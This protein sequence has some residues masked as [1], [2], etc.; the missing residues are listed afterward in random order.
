[1]NNFP[2]SVPIK[3]DIGKFGLMWPRGLEATSHP[4]SKMLT[5]YSVKG[6]PVEMNKNCSLGHIMTALKRGPHVSAKQPDANRYLLQ[7]TQ[8]KIQQGF[9]SKV[10]WG[11]IKHNHP[12]NLK[13]SPL[14]MI[15]HKSRSYRCILDLSFQLKVKKTL[16]TSVNKDTNVKAPQ[17]SMAQLGTVI[18]RIVYAMADNHNT[19]FPF[20][21]S[22]CDIKDGFWRMVVSLMDAWNFAYTLPSTTTLKNL[23]DIEIIVPHALQMGW[24][25]SPPYFCAATETGRDVI[26]SYYTKND[27]IPKHPLERYLITK[28]K[29][30]QPRNNPANPH[31]SFE[32]Y[33]DD[34]ITLTND[35]S[36]E[37]ITKMARAML[38]GIH[39]IFPPPSITHHQGED[40]I[41][42]K[43]LLQL[44]GMFDY[45]KEILGWN[46]NGKN[47]TIELPVEK[48]HKILEILNKT[49]KLKVIPHKTLEKIQGKLVHIST[50]LPNSRGLLSPLYKAVAQQ[51]HPT[52]LNKNLKQCLTD[53]KTLVTN[54]GSRP[55]SILELVPRDPNYIGFVDASGTGVGGVWTP[56]TSKIQPTVWRV[57]W[58]AEIQANLVSKTNPQGTISINDMETAGILLAWLVLEKI[59]PTV[60]QHKHIGIHCDNDAAV[61]WTQKKSTATST[62][63]GHLLRALALR[64][65]THQAAPLQVI[66]IKGKDNTMADVASRSFHDANLT[67][68]TKFLQSFSQKFPLQQTSWKEYHMPKKIYSKVTS[69]LLGQPS[70]M[71][72]WTKII[73]QERSTGI[74]GQNT[75]THSTSA[76]T[77]QHVPTQ[78]KSYL[79]QDLLQG[80][81]QVT[82]AKEGLSGFR[83]LQKRWQP[84]Q[85]PSN[86]LANLRQST[87]QKKL[88]NCQWHGS[89]KDTGDKILLQHHNLHSQSVCQNNASK[90]ENN[91]TT[92]T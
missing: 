70:T 79:S 20:V 27:A 74:T 81:G 85:R 37:N 63:A 62:I 64:L 17:K 32:V 40:P 92:L 41:S 56:G 45:T 52:P 14:A 86:W 50:G 48:Q 55:T 13:L 9:M 66:H 4:A 21:F 39:S 19:N 1:M 46:F 67:I 7:E 89:L 5:N 18:K 47:F 24:A 76:T 44:E 80:S 10:R 53:W 38:H 2:T 68:Q 49:C 34:Y 8:M 78:K 73:K 88:T 75:Q 31:S 58:P 12:L 43:K 28:L 23:D 36:N 30:Q 26:E 33:V 22:K 54:I 59:T 15:P 82:T 87:K 65:H 16:Q 77:C 60:L 61:N 6:C 11:D 83:A 84:S 69:S 91:Q 35:T 90:L 71:A 72:L 3:S 29:S 51:Q 25:E 57:Q 42:M